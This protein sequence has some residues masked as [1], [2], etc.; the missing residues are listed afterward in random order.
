LTTVI[1]YSGIEAYLL[2]EFIDKII[3]YVADKSS[4]KHQQKIEIQYNFVGE[5]AG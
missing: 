3:M 1:R 4:G 2:R 5:L